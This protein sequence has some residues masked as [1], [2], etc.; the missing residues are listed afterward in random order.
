MGCRCPSIG[1]LSRVLDSPLR[2]GSRRIHGVVE[3]RDAVGVSRK[4]GEDQLMTLWPLFAAIG[5]LI[6][7]RTPDSPNPVATRCIATAPMPVVVLRGTDPMPVHG[8]D[9]HRLSPMPVMAH[10]ACYITRSI[11]V[12]PA[13]RAVP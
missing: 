10:R 7:W 5:L 8:I 9:V 6:A 4:T 13:R 1:R 12:M 3:A 11:Q 2:F